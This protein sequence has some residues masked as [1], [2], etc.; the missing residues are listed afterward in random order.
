MVL[1]QWAAPISWSM[2][3]DEI[4]L[5]KNESGHP[6]EPLA[7]VRIGRSLESRPETIAR[8]PGRLADW[9]SVDID[10]ESRRILCSVAE[11][12]SDLWLYE[13]GPRESSSEGPS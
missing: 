8:R 2:S 9:S 1:D 7:L 6:A 3:G 4:Y 11:R 13:R 10:A 5:I 12:R